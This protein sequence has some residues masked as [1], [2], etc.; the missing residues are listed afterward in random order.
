MFFMNLIILGFSV[1][2]VFSVSVFIGLISLWF[3]NI[4]NDLGV[5]GVVMLLIT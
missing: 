1:L 3:N 2:G 4:Y 5:S